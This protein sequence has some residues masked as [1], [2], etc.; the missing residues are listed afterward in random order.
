MDH[1]KNH[2][3][4]KRTILF[5]ASVICVAL[6]TAVFAFIWYRY[7]SK[8]MFVV[9]FYRRGNWAV[10]GIYYVITFFFSSTYG[11]LKI[12]QLKR[13][14]VLLSQYLSI[15]LSDLVAYG[16][17]SLLAFR[18][19]N[20]LLL[21]AAMAVQM[22]ISSIWDLFT[23]RIYGKLFQPWKILLIYEGSRPAADLVY[24]VDQRRDKYVIS[25]AVNID[26][27]IEAIR[28]KTEKNEAV[29]IGDI[30]AVKRNDILKYCFANNIRAYVVPK[31]S[32]II[33]M[34]GDHIHVFDSPLIL[35]KGYA[36]SFD[37]RFMKRLFDILL[38][39]PLIIITSPVM[40]VTAAA[41][42]LY[43]G[44]P[45]FYRQ[46]RCTKDIKEF[47]I[48]KFRSM[49]VNAEKHGAQLSTKNDDRITPVGK[50]IRA[51]RIDELP[52][53]FN[54]LKGDMSFVG[55]RPERPE[56]IKDYCETMP[57]FPFRNRVKA[58]LTGY[59]QV[60]GK[61]NTTPYDKLKL[62]LFYIENY[63]IWLDIK[64]FLM[65][66]K[67]VFKKDSTEG[68]DDGSMT[69]EREADTENVEEVIH[70]IS[71][72]KTGGLH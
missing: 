49:I 51:T 30:S 64:L 50:F 16:I 69:A 25:D 6:I 45:V 56:I 22:F 28:K 65:T 29:I 72:G 63:S 13:G 67:T 53:F 33:L 55:P 24:K 48:I 44:G 42:K 5:L 32:D 43:D 3:E 7:Y 23:M 8:T 17:I 12:G 37:Q 1:R 20:P 54:I 71:D 34:G 40:L 46:V 68:I 26:D 38:S 70:N 35:S 36:L 62:D 39:V 9:S 60:Y 11:G 41:I 2:D 14:E 19:V 31:I 18:L 27:G 58:G 10:I 57:E 4:Y 52:Q 61:Y 66:V 21:L 47:S 15:F 59:A